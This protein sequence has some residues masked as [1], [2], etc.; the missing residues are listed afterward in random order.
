MRWGSVQEHARLCLWC[1]ARHYCREAMG[2]LVDKWGFGIL[3]WGAQVADV[4]DGF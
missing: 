3:R 2:S 4:E 1:R